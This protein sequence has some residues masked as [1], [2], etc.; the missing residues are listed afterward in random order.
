MKKGSLLTASAG[1]AVFVFTFRYSE[2]FSEGVLIGLKNCASVIIPSLFPFMV[3][4]SF[5]GFAELPL[6]VKRLA[7]PVT[8]LLFGQPSESI[9]AVIP[10]FFG[11]YPSGAKAACALAEGG[12]ISGKNAERLMLFCVNGGAGF[13]VN[14]VG[15]SMLGNKNAGRIIFVSMCLAAVVTGML[16]RRKDETVCVSKTC[17]NRTFSEIFVESVASASKGIITVC[18]Y[19]ALFSGVISVLSRLGFDEKTVAFM[20]CMLEVT[21]GCVEIAGKVPVSAVAAVCAF[22]GLC[23]HMQIFA[24]AGKYKPK[25]SEFYFYRIVH[26]LLSGLICEFLLMIFPVAE[27]TALTVSENAGAWSFSAPAAISLVFLS[28]LLI[29][30]LDKERKIC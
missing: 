16:T 6:L 28:S 9:A 18:A 23:V 25:I 11:G 20:A 22:G 8:N 30:E 29:L 26:S 7:D 5:M 10:G 3:V 24:V 12:K 14:A 15:I 21:S 4:S 13:C 2:A 1:I 27:E 17:E 19:T